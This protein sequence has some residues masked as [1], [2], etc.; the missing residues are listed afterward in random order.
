M[1]N[2]K[3]DQ[4]IQDGSM[5]LELAVISVLGDREDQQDCFGYS[6]KPGEG[7]IAVCDGMGGHEGG[8]LA[9]SVAVNRMISSYDETYPHVEISSFLLEEVHKADREVYQLAREDGTLLRAG[10]TVCAVFVKDRKL[11]WVSV[12]DSRIY[13]LR[14]EEF[15][16]ITHDHNYRLALDEHLAAGAISEEEYQREL[17]RGEALISFLGLGE[18]KI[19]DINTVPFELQKDDRIILMSDG[20]Y[21]LASDE[22]IKRILLNFNNISDALQALEMK[23]KKNAKYATV[24]RDNM[25]VALVRIK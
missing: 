5:E 3:A 22:E 9:S 23:A 21:K 11:S 8:R 17:A 2:Y 12:G 7:L 25:T 20:L 14:D 19:I 1:Q 24:K 13:L 4:L 10:T 6:L 16:Q 15:V 18:L